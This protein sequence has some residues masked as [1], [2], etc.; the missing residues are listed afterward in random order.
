MI[1]EIIPS[2][3]PIEMRL[4]FD[5][6]HNDFVHRINNKTF[7]PFPDFSG[8]DKNILAWRSKMDYINWFGQP[9]VN[10]PYKGDADYTRELTWLSQW[11]NP[12]IVV[13]IG[14]DKGAGTFLFDRLNPE[15][16]IYTIDIAN[17]AY[18]PDNNQVEIG[19]FSK[20]NN[21]TVYYR[22]EK[23]EVKANFIFIDGDHSEN[24]VWED[25]LWAWE[26]IDKARRWVI[27]W[28]DAREG[29]EQFIGL[30]KSIHRFSDF[31]RK[32]VYRFSDSCTVWMTGELE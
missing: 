17:H 24:A 22:K 6:W 19:F 23:P 11:C 5:N 16:E 7:I 27:V 15:S 2:E 9:P 21:C 3:L 32:K 10:E 25:S 12:E 4:N 28:H 29:D 8:E 1:K 20:L 13:E 14:T 18:I 30:L 26:H 31:T